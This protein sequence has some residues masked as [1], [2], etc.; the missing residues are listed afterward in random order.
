MPTNIKIN[1]AT[2]SVQ[3][4]TYSQKLVYH[5]NKRYGRRREYRGL[6]VRFTVH[7]FKGKQGR[8]VQCISFLKSDGTANP[9]KNKIRFVFMTDEEIRKKIGQALR[10]ILKHKIRAPDLMSIVA[11]A[12][13][14][15]Y[16]QPK[17]TLFK[18][19]CEEYFE[20]FT[21][22]TLADK[23]PKGKYSTPEMYCRYHQTEDIGSDW[24]KDPN[25][26][27]FHKKSLPV[28]SG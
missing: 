8:N 12:L 9:K 11:H 19:S 22:S 5:L 28:K 2:F 24:I 21:E 13:A 20:K 6:L 16:H 15:I 18:K 1:N 7:R 25:K 3:P 26:I 14:A 27:P 4:Y 17:S 10:N 23:K